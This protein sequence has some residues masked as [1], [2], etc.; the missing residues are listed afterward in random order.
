[1]K[2]LVHANACG[3]SGF[4]LLRGR[5]WTTLGAMVFGVGGVGG[6]GRITHGGSREGA[7]VALHFVKNPLPMARPVL[8]VK[9]H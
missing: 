1:M 4:W 7:D 2:L 8:P 9:G 5:A 6:V 3:R